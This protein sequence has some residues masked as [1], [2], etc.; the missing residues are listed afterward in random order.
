MSGRNKLII[1]NWKLHFTV[2]QAAAYAKKLAEKE[3][4]SGVVVGA[5]PH[6][7]ALASVADAL[8]GS[9]I[10][11]A[12]QNAYSQDEGA[13]T[14][15][16]SMPMLRGIS[17]YCII[18]HSERRHIFHESNEL[19]KAKVASAFRSNILPVLCIGETLI[20]KQHGHTGQV[21][22]DQIA[23]GLSLLTHEEVSRLIIAYE[24][25]WAIG[26]GEFA[27]PDD[28]EKAV[29]LIRREV[30]E[31]FGNQA[32]HDVRVLYGGSVNK[33]NAVSYT[34]LLGVDGLLVG[35][36]SLS[37]ATFWPIVEAAANTMPKKILV[38]PGKK[39]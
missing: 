20:E 24:P 4:P 39:D 14:G 17:G 12:A 38:K 25:V 1:G 30:N 36:A 21:L 7:L 6:A 8:S 32:A 10:K 5:A 2:K 35:G 18:G 22:R 3:V 28:V 29:T 34:K 31:L 16:I 27:R 26:T 37:V 19:I 15:E 13:F 33:D 9:K 23:T 11:L